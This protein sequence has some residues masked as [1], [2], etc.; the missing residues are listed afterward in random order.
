MNKM[1]SGSQTREKRI[2][3]TT[4][5]KKKKTDYLQRNKSQTRAKFFDADKSQESGISS[6]G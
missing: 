3:K 5:P 2:V 6:Q 1:S 4:R